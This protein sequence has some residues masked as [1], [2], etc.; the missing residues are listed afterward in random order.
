[1]NSDIQTKREKVDQKNEKKIVSFE[2]Q[3][4]CNKNEIVRLRDERDFSSIHA[5][6]AK[7]IRIWFDICS[8]SWITINYETYFLSLFIYLFG[9]K[10]VISSNWFQS[11]N[12][13]EENS[14]CKKLCDENEDKNHSTSNI[15]WKKSQVIYEIFPFLLL[16]QKRR[17]FHL[18]IFH[19]FSFSDYQLAAINFDRQK[20]FTISSLL[21]PPFVMD[22]TLGRPKFSQ[23]SI[24]QVAYDLIR[25]LR[26]C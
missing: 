11:R 1:M 26:K 3:I 20:V 21:L 7:F 2:L 18:L 16:I 8:R 14:K 12:E 6:D 4:V 5:H 13:G 15:L 17:G 24:D 25:I 10:V 23:D 19:R 9:T 22:L